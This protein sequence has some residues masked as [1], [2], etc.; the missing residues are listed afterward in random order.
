MD[1]LKSEN[2]L[3]MI[4]NANKQ[5]MGSIKCYKDRICMISGGLFNEETIRSM[6]S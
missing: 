3:M 5:G 2:I 4:R 1:E 6:S